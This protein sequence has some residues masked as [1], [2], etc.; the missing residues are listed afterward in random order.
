MKRL[1][2]II[3][4][5]GIWVAGSLHMAFAQQHTEDK[6]VEETDTF[7]IPAPRGDTVFT[8]TAIDSIKPMKKGWTRLYLS[9]NS[10]KSHV[11]ITRKTG[12]KEGDTFAGKVEKLVRFKLKYW[13]IKDTPLFIK[14]DGEEFLFSRES[15]DSHEYYLDR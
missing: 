5:L 9:G 7:C 4:V 13:E 2:T 3:L 6:T 12:Y 15:L 1:L 10:D 11:V 14:L 8:A